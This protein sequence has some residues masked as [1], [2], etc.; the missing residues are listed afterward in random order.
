MPPMDMQI[1][2]PLKLMR[3]KQAAE[4]KLLATERRQRSGVLKEQ[5]KIREA[6][7]AEKAANA[8]RLITPLIEDPS[9]DAAN[10]DVPQ[11]D[12][13]AVLLASQATGDTAPQGPTGT[14]TEDPEILPEKSNHPRGRIHRTLT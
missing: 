10:K 9:G 11:P 8:E 12:P 1:P 13:L 6:E 7:A 14:Q 2:D 3:H 5:A 4:A